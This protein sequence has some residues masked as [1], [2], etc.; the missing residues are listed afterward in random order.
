MAKFVV[1]AMLS[2]GMDADLDGGLWF[3][4]HGCRGS[5]SGCPPTRSSAGL[6][7]SEHLSESAPVGRLGAAER[8]AVLRPP[9]AGQARFDFGNVQL[10]RVGIDGLGAFLTKHSLL[11]GVG[12]D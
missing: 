8:D 9:R 2:R 1:G 7:S 4:R 12:L 5:V 6:T 11:F 3:D 10:Q